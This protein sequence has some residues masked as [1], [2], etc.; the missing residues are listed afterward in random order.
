MRLRS[1]I[2]IAALASVTMAAAPPPPRLD[3]I[4][5][6]TGRT[7]GENVM[8]QPFVGPTP[9]IVDSVGRM[10]GKEFVMIDTVHEGKKPV[11]TRKWVMREDGPKPLQGHTHRCDRAGRYRSQREWRGDPL[12]HEGRT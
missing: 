1:A 2:A 9:L 10:D 7:H 4:P 12:H 3:M 6:F 5:F 11:R 8:S